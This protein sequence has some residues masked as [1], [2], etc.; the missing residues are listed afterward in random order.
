MFV[1]SSLS[2]LGHFTGGPQDI[3]AALREVSGT[4]GL[5]THTYT[6][7]EVLGEAAPVFDPA[8]TPSQNGH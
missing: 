3:L 6:Y 5:P 2:G 4:L 7:P 1:H 8:T